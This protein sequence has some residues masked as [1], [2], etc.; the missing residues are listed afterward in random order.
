M[1]NFLDNSAHIKAKAH[2]LRQGM[3]VAGLD[4]PW[5]G[6]PFMLQGFLITTEEELEHLRKLCQFV[7]IDPTRSTVPLPQTTRPDPEPRSKPVSGNKI[8]PVRQGPAPNLRGLANPAAFRENLKVAARRQNHARRYLQSTF[9]DVRLGA[10]VNTIEAQ[11]IVAGL[12]ESITT[13]VNAALWLTNLKDRDEYTLVHSMNVCVLSIA[14]ARHLGFGDEELHVIGL[15]ALLHDLGKI[16]TPDDV[17]NKPGRLTGDEFAIMKRHPVDGYELLADTGDLPRASLQIVRHH[18]ERIDGS[19][20]PD[21]WGGEGIPLPVLL[22]SVVDVYDAVTSDRCYHVGRSPHEGLKLLYDIAPNNFG[23]ELIE[24]FIRCVGIYPIGSLVELTDGSLGIVLSADPD[25]RLKPLVRIVR[26]PSGEPCADCAR[27]NLAELAG[28]NSGH[29]RDWG[30]R[31]VLNPTDY[32]IDIK[33]IVAEDSDIGELIALE[34]VG[35]GGS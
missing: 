6:T 19:G 13:N 35:L 26:Q 9:N 24:E 33:A 5:K 29:W 15:G 4:R 8:R 14:F 20:Y 30:I 2:T 22:T 28:H 32:D 12:V 11:A 21:G 18:H 31:R 23:R 1:T 16:K 27:I 7:Y 34:P 10:S 3:F 17:L 25:H